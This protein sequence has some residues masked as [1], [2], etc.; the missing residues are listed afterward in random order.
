MLITIFTVLIIS[1]NL[2]AEKKS[3]SDIASDILEKE[4]GIKYFHLNIPSEIVI[5][6]QEKFGSDVSFDDAFRKAMKAFMYPADSDGE[7][8]YWMVSELFEEFIESLL[9][10]PAGFRKESYSSILYRLSLNKIWSETINF[11]SLETL[12]LR[13]LF[14]CQEYKCENNVISS[15]IVSDDKYLKQLLQQYKDQYSCFRTKEDSVCMSDFKNTDFNKYTAKVILSIIEKWNAALELES[16]DYSMNE[17]GQE[18]KDYWVFSLYIEDLS[19][20]GHWASVPR[21]G[22]GETVTCNFN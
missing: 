6:Q 12:M 21:K 19:D 3:C 17:C 20:H 5:Y 2:F 16:I 1:S 15:K 14:P 11:K 8:I 18:V 10:I 22:N 4:Y 9:K 13:V 7:H